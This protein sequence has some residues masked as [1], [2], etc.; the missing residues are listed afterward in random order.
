[1]LQDGNA[2]GPLEELQADQKDA[3]WRSF[4]VATYR[5]DMGNIY[6]KMGRLEDANAAYAAAQKSIEDAY[7][8]STCQPNRVPIS[9]SFRS[10]GRSG[11]VLPKVS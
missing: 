6:L 11:D 5:R 9:N 10:K 1:M 7:A 2:Y 8:A 3:A 4:K